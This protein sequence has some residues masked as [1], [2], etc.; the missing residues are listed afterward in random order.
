[1]WKP[2][3]LDYMMN[4]AHAASFHHSDP[5]STLLPVDAMLEIRRTGAHREYATQQSIAGLDL[6]R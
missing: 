5:L 1:M 6:R 3:A 2:A 4:S